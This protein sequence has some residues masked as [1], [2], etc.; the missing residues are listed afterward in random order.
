[1]PRIGPD[2]DKFDAIL[3]RHKLKK[4]ATFEYDNPGL[5]RKSVV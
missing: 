2:Y 5:D 1:M 3:K 4:G